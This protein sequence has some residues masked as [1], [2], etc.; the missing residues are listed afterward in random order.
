MRC[1]LIET[2]AISKGTI[3]ILLK[4]NINRFIDDTI[5]ELEIYQKESKKLNK[6]SNINFIQLFENIRLYYTN[7][8]INEIITNLRQLED[9]DWEELAISLDFLP[10][11]TIEL[12]R[13]VKR[14]I[15]LIV[16]QML[17][18]IQ[19]ILPWHSDIENK[20]SDLKQLYLN[21]HGQIENNL[22]HP[23]LLSGMVQ[24]IFY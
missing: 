5:K 1:N 9:I 2:S 11:E 4:N 16:S 14:V 18:E 6:I 20:C 10:E 15:E 8:D 22:N 7:V 17:L 13:I 23:T 3:N 24:V 12:E 19:V 21:G